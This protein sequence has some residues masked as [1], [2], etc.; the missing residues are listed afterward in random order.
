MQLLTLS[1]AE[2]I[3]FKTQFKYRLSTVLIAFFI[4]AG[5]TIAALVGAVLAWQQEAWLGVFVLGWIVL[6]F[7]LFSWMVFSR[8][9]GR[10]KSTNWLVRTR[11]GEML[12][13]FRSYMN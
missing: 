8:I 1:Q 12:V 5:I 7:F 2:L 10:L 11:E 9:K 4:T 6:W 3:P 13:K